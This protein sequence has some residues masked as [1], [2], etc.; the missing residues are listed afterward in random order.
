MDNNENDNEWMDECP[1]PGQPTDKQPDRI[2][3]L[4]SVHFSCV[5]VCLKE[6]FDEFNGFKIMAM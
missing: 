5:S 6:I 4:F 2:G 1:I 3:K